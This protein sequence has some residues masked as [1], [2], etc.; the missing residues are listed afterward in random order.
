MEAIA[1]RLE[2]VT[3]RSKD[4]TSNKE[5]S[6]HPAGRTFRSVFRPKAMAGAMA[7]GGTNGPN[8]R[9][10]IKKNPRKLSCA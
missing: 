3:T 1:N 4:A 7:S 10:R 2:A 8:G 9:P 5:S 6:S